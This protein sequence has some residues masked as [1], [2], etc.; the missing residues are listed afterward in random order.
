M[1]L[2]KAV[3]YKLA[4][5]RDE[6]EA[7]Y[8]L[9]Y[10]RYCAKGYIPAHWN[11]DIWVTPYCALPSTYVFI[12]KLSDK[13]IGTISVFQ[14]SD[15]GLPADIIWKEELD[16]LRSEKKMLCEIGM[17]AC[18]K[19]IGSDENP[20]KHMGS[21]IMVLCMFKSI[22]ELAKTMLSE[23]EW[24][25]TVNPA[26]MHFYQIIGFNPVS[27][28]A[29]DYS[30]LTNAPAVVLK[31]N[32]NDVRKVIE[33]KAFLRKIFLSSSIDLDLSKKYL[34]SEKDIDYFFKQKTPLWETLNKTTQN[35]LIRN[36]KSHK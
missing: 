36:L 28:S 7:A 20:L 31:A 25:I 23:A 17:L 8:R 4:D 12:A 1:R 35:Y 14:D 9:V 19:S 24:F 5:S 15:I 18:D 32:F 34:W 33:K 21:F 27:K 6:L 3:K 13:V 10:Q 2:L 30:V 26:H 16:S 22:F 29:V 11:S